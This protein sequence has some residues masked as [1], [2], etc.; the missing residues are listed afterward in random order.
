MF[1]VVMH[2]KGHDVWMAEPERQRRGFFFFCK[3]KPVKP[4][5][6]RPDLPHD[7]HTLKSVEE[8]SDLC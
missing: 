2:V 6:K 8:N 4:V 5:K 3:M 1:L 7:E